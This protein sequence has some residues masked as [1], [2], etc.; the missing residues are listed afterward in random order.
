VAEEQPTLLV[1]QAVEE[2]MELS[3]SITKNSKHLVELTNTKEWH[4]DS[5]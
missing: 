2:E 5:N 3:I 4:N 1:P